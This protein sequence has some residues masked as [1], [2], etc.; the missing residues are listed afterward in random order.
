MDIVKY[1]SDLTAKFNEEEKCDF[2]WEFS[3][4]LFEDAVN[5]V[6][7]EEA[8]C[9]QLMLTDLKEQNRTSYASTGFVTG[10]TTTYSFTLYAL[11]QGKLGV[12]NYN[13]IKGHDVITSN[14]VQIF[15]PLR[16][17]LSDSAIASDC[18]LTGLQVELPAWDF[19]TVRNYQ[20]NNYNG[21]RINGAILVRNEN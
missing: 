8:C 13:E 9:V 5:I 18:E 4:P 16:D 10:K 20:D 2:C 11:I 1:F 7:N 3:A 6:Q 12:N 17:C 14:W 19:Q 15:K 21:W